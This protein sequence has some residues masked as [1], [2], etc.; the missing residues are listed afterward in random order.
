MRAPLLNACV[1]TGRTWNRALMPPD[2]R[3]QRPAAKPTTEFVSEAD[4]FDLWLRRGLQARFAAVVAEPLPPALVELAIG[5][6]EPVRHDTARFATAEDRFDE[7]VRERAYFLWLEEG[8]PEGRALEHWMAAFVQQVA[9]EA[10]GW[11]ATV[12]LDPRLAPAGDGS[13]PGSGVSR[14]PRAGRARSGRG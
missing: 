7:R 13:R 8:Q 6:T 4:A 3:D 11:P 5:A 9:Q 1:L 14:L 12:A 10:S 2:R